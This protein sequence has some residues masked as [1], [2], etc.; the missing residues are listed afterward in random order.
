M[1]VGNNPEAEIDG[2]PG[3][4]KVTF[5]GQAPVRVLGPVRVG[6]LIIPSGENDGSAIAVSPSVVGADQVARVIGIAWASNES[7]SAG[8]VNTAIGVNQ[9]AAAAQVIAAHETRIA[10][11]E[12]LVERIASL[13]SGGAK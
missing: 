2:A 6:D 10:K 12:A 4:Q 1:L 9:F 3:Y 13:E 8:L 5:I 11:L 7:V